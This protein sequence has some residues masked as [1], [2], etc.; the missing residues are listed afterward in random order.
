MSDKPQTGHY[1]VGGK[2]A[3]CNVGEDG[4]V[5]VFYDDGW[6]TCADIATF[7]RWDTR[8]VPEAPPNA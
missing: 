3:N 7:Q 6:Y 5:R 4:L 1:L 2:L 8:P